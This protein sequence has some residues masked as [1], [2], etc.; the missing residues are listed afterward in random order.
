M[1]RLFPEVWT[2]ERVV[3]T[4]GTA[5]GNGPRLNGKAESA[6]HG[7]H[8]DPR[9]AGAGLPMGDTGSAEPQQ[10]E[11]LNHFLPIL[12]YTTSAVHWSCPTGCQPP[13]VQS[14]LRSVE[15]ESPAVWPVENRQN[16]HPL[17]LRL[18]RPSQT[19]SFSSEMILLTVDFPEFTLTSCLRGLTEL[20]LL[21]GY[22]LKSLGNRNIDNWYITKLMKSPKASPKVN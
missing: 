13:W 20:T 9:Q 10:V 4:T 7:G 15:K 3:G 17:Y 2:G 5:V 18:L 12:G 21:S 11:K 22:E 14:R 19:A 16:S 6:L 8:G 1:K